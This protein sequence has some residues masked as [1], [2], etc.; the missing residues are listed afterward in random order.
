MDRLAAPEFRRLGESRTRGERST[1]NPVVMPWRCPRTD[2]SPDRDAGGPVQPIASIS[3]PGDWSHQ[4]VR[5]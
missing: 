4:D 5:R 2:Q 3:I 1:A